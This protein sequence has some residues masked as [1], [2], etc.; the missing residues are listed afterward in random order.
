MNE[1]VNILLGDCSG[2]L[3]GTKSYLVELKMS[4]NVKDIQ[5]LVYL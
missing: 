5:K 1:W 4:I 3:A 2:A